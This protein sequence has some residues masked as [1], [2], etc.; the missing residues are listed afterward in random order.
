MS[1]SCPHCHQINLANAL[2]C[3]RC[4]QSLSAASPLP[5]PPHDSDLSSDH[6][7]ITQ[8][9]TEYALGTAFI[10]ERPARRAKVHTIVLLAIVCLL[11]LAGGSTAAIVLHIRPTSSPSVSVPPLPTPGSAR[12][13]YA[14]TAF[15]YSIQ[16][17]SP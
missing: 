2:F 3:S 7:V 11:I 16:Y 4:G 5:S 6:N 17:P 1:M 15:S 10:Q 14:N 12:T 9:R 8:D 13:T